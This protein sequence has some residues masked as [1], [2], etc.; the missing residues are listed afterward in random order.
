[1]AT[2]TSLSREQ[3]LAL[4]RARRYAQDGTARAIREAHG[5]SLA[6]MAEGIGVVTATIWRW[7]HG[8]TEPRGM[9]AVR[10]CQLLEDLQK[11]E[12]PA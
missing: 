11:L 8:E 9:A 2:S 12:T 4:A 3:V 6:N 5:L 10:W 7:E 1:M